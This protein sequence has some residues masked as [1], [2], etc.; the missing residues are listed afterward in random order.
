MCILVA[1]KLDLLKQKHESIVLERFNEF[2]SWRTTLI[3]M[4]DI[5][6]SKTDV[7]IIAV[8]VRLWE[9]TLLLHVAAFN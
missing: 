9:A 5:I 8:A 2:D 7:S 4:A 1:Q 6:H 3:Y